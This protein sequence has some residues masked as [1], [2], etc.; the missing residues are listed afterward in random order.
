MYRARLLQQRRGG[1]ATEDALAGNERYLQMA[2]NFASYAIDNLAAL[3][4]IPD[5][6]RPHSQFEGMT[7]LATLLLDLQ[8]PEKAMFPCFE[9]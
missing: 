2:R 7:G 9:F 3:A 8:D 6:P 5:R 1:G 4:N